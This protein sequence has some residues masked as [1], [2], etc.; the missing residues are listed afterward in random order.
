MFPLYPAL[1]NRYDVFYSS[2]SWMQKV[3]K[4]GK[5]KRELLPSYQTKLL[6]EIFVGTFEEETTSFTE[7][8]V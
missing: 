2:N 1:E 6:I 4:L 7:I 3:Y 8:R 5:F